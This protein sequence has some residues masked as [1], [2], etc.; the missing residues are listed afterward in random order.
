[1]KA[2]WDNIDAQITMQKESL[3]NFFVHYL[4]FFG[5]KDRYSAS[6]L[7][8]Y[9]ALAYTI[10][11]HIIE[12]WLATKVLYNKSHSKRIYYLSM[13]YLLGRLFSNNI[14]NLG[15]DK[16]FREGLKKLGV[17]WEDYTPWERESALGNGGLGRLAA[18][19]LDSMATL[20][21]PA[22][23]YGLRYEYG[24]FRQD[25]CQGYQVEEPDEWLKFD[26]IWEM[27]RIEHTVPVHFGGEV[28][29]YHIDGV[30]KF[31]WCPSYT[32]LGIPYDMPV[33][34]YGNNIVNTLRLWSAKVSEE[35]DL[36]DF[37]QGNYIDAVSEKV[38]GETLT[39]VLYPDDRTES[40][41]ELRFRQQYFFVCCS[42][43]DIMRKFLKESS[44]FRDFPKKAVIQLNDTHPS[45]SIAELMR[46]LVD[47]KHLPWDVAWD[48]TRK[49]FGYTN[50]TILPEALEKWP[51]EFFQRHLP[52]H[53]QIIYKLN[54][55]FLQ[56]VSVQNPGDN[57]ILRRMSLV[58]EYPQ[59][60]I[61]MAHLAII[62]STSVNG[63]SEIH[64]EILKEQV[65]PDFYNS[66]PH[67]FNNKT[68]GITPRRWLLQAN[69]SLAK[70][71]TEKIGK[72]WITD[73]SQLKKLEKYADDK[74]F[75]KRFDK[76][77]LENKKKLA[78]L[79]EIETGVVVEDDAIFDVQIKRIHE[80]KR[81]L[82][83]ILHVIHLYCELRDHKNFKDA[84]QRV[85][86]FAGKAAPGYY[87][88]KMIIKLILNVAKVINND[89]L[90]KDK[91][92]VVFI[93]NYKVSLAET[94][95]PATDISE[96]IST[97]GKE[98]SGT[99]NMKFALNGA[100]TIGTLD[101][102][103]I[104]IMNEVGKENIFTFGLDIDEIKAKREGNYEPYQ[105]YSENPNIKKVID[106]IQSNFF[107]LHE[108]GIFE[109]I[110]NSLL[111]QDQYFVFADFNAY[112]ECHEK[113]LQEYKNQKQWT[114][115]AILNVARM[116]KF[117]SD[118][119]INEYAAD[120]WKVSPVK[121]KKGK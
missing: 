15:A 22:I 7:D 89:E 85:F 109:P 96:Q 20:N 97:A 5:G 67:K 13:E 60:K 46:I 118:R 80:Y 81:Q 47:E 73:L 33:V 12:K 40:G 83:N 102:A 53:L 2:N 72:E 38:E 6:E 64:S 55:H 35:F 86:L 105:L 52:R 42:I 24:I 75:R 9:N 106:L 79:I 100:L 30:E 70:L 26:N 1:M 44:D 104:E 14:I 90:I 41:R 93:P 117:S 107:S 34:G 56:E 51:V 94:I 110:C 16:E 18:C 121:P 103:N 66:F 19:F 25:I 59:K 45:I 23:G 77:K 37:N 36:Q 88:A 112:M 113:I 57:D 115:K 119:T 68:N 27:K 87:M 116:G 62:G 76:I 48:I 65:M 32:V 39:K 71:I 63:V 43:Q 111:T 11:D 84:P 114:K 10:R 91:I 28:E 31:N 21:L 74:D 78:K 101:G 50:H 95:I 3:A 17:D 54:Q 82:M 99:G 49:S 61:R 98:A 92:K 29:T 8:V 120:I 4:K 108:P 69:P 58:E